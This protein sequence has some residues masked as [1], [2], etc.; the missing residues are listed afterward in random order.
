[1]KSVSAAKSIKNINPEIN[2]I[3]HENRV[4]VETENI[5]NE[6]FYNNLDG[7][8]NALDNIEARKYVDNRCIEFGKP[9]ESGTLGTKGNVQV[10]IP[11]LTL[12]FGSTRDP[13]QK[14]VPVCTLKNFPYLIEHTI[15]NARD[16]FEGIFKTSILDTKKYLKDPSF[17]KTLSDN[18]KTQVYKNIKFVLDNIPQNF[19]DCIKT[20]YNFWH[21]E[22][23]N[24]ICQLIH[25]FPKNHLTSSG[26]PFWSGTKKFPKNLLNLI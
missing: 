7:V 26:L 17:I 13:P 8:A 5:Y 15:Q 3:A 2:I 23:R 14:S 12:S 16:N 9:L 24:K 10:I 4:G 6:D 22:F 18:D 19:D 1:M 11:N 20:S 25:K 21:D